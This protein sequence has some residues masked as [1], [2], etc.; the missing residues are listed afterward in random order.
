MNNNVILIG[1]FNF[2]NINWKNLSSSRAIDETFIECIQDNLLTQVVME[3]TR[4]NNILD[5]ALVGD[6]TS[7]LEC[8]IDL[9]PTVIITLSG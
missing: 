7:L 9:S 8:K 2:R 5:L 4:G 1:N 6:P 3:P